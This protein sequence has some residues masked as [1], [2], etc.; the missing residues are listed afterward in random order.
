MR[1]GTLEAGWPERWPADDSAAD[2]AAAGGGFFFDVMAVG[3]TEK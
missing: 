3:I 2:G 1:P